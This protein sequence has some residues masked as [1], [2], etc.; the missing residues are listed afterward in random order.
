[1]LA[2]RRQA[3]VALSQVQRE[4]VALRWHKVQVQVEPSLHWAARGLQAWHYVRSHPWAV[5]APVAA[6]AMLRPRWGPRITAGFFALSRLRRL[7]R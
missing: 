7:L 6:L 1:M 5:I 3:L 2:A 4:V